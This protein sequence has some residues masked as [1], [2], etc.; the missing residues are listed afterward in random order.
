MNTRIIVGHDGS[1]ASTAALHWAATR[2]DQRGLALRIVG[3]FALPPPLDFYGVGLSMASSVEREHLHQ[4]CLGGLRSAVDVVRSAHPSVG[5]DFEAV[6][7]DPPDAILAAA[8]S[9]GVEMIALGASGAGAARSFLLGSVASAVAHKSAMP[10]VL[11]PADLGPT[12]KRIVVGTDGS[13][14]SDRALLWSAEEAAS[15]DSD[16]VVVHA[17]KYPYRLTQAGF[18]RGMDIAEID[19]ALVLERAVALAQEH[20]IT[21][22]TGQLTE[23]GAVDAL[24]WASDSAD[25]VVLGSRGRGGFRSMLLGS[26]TLNVAAHTSCPVV[27]TH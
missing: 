18:D 19:A 5:V 27:I 16:L 4:A 11:V 2:A 8:N 26:V 20:T 24:L 12:V 1:P 23:E 13:E 15:T 21:K 7:A 10:V 3:S 25:M 9:A 14:I 17:W 22:V 6:E